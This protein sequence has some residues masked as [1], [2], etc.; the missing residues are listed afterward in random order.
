MMQMLVL[1]LVLMPMLMLLMML[2]LMLVP[3]LM[4]V[5]MLMLMLMHAHADAYD[6]G[7]GGGRYHAPVWPLLEDSQAPPSH[8]QAVTKHPL[9]STQ[10]LPSPFWPLPRHYQ[11]SWPLLVVLYKCLKFPHFTQCTAK[12]RTRFLKSPPMQLG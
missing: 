3:M 11:A 8:Y 10:P 12:P 1:V 6:M 4:L 5:L 7:G 2:M 9:A